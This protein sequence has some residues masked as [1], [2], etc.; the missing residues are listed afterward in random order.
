MPG[1]AVVL[2]I[3]VSSKTNLILTH[4]MALRKRQD[5]TVFDRDGQAIVER[6]WDLIEFFSG[7][8]RV[9][10]MSGEKI[11]FLVQY[12]KTRTKTSKTKNR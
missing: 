7:I 3:L 2:A 10:R 11:R 5:C 12:C 9:V 6:R 4:L 8:A 1:T